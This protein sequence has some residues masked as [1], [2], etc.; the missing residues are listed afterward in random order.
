VKN[1][2]PTLFPYQRDGAEWLATKRLALLADE[3]GLGKSAQAI[4]AADAINAK[5]ILVIC[6]AIA[7]VN[8]V[9]EFEKFSALSRPWTK[10]LKN[11]D[12]LLETTSIVTSFD[13]AARTP[14]YGDVDLMIVD[15]AHFLKSAEAKRAQA[16]LGKTGHV[17]RAKRVW[18][19]TG[20]PAPNHYGELWTI[21]VTFGKTKLSYTEFLKRYCLLWE[22]SYGLRV[23]GV[24]KENLFELREILASVMLRRRKADV[25]TELPPISFSEMLVEPSEV[26]LDEQ[27]SFVQYA[28]VPGGREFLAKKLRQEAEIV[29]A[30]FDWSGPEIQR[31]KTLEAVA[32][33][34]STL[35]RYTGLQKVQGVASIIHD[36]LENKAYE[37]I[38]I[39]AIHR[40]VIDGM[41]AALT[42]F[43]PMTLYGGFDDEKKQRNLSTFQK[44]P[45]CRVMVANIMTAGTAINL[46][47]ASEVAFIEQDWVPGNNAQAVMRCHRIGQTKPVNVR[48]FAVADSLD[49]SIAKALKRKTR[50]ITDLL[51]EPK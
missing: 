11:S 1:E 49:E 33:S 18:C 47:V 40:D 16:I 25:M 46:T 42:K 21:L 43:N 10:Q 4:T 2:I 8:W 31:I 41:R 37:K 13:L 51:D 30:A 27:C 36:E 34:V 6:P 39:F 23:K 29:K 14:S 9:K 7:R 17:R 48:F 24:R 5:R 35:R 32:N 3:M 38:V 20:T 26:I 12:H 44:N 19:L 28:A 15:E 50:D 45:R 22:S